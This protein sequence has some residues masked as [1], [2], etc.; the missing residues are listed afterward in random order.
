MKETLNTLT[1][2]ADSESEDVSVKDST[3]GLV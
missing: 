3:Q 2:E 1:E